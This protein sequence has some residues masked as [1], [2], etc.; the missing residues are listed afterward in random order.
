MKVY[1]KGSERICS[2]SLYHPTRGE[3][4]EWFVDRLLENIEGND[5]CEKL[6]DEDKNYFNADCLMTKRTYARLYD[7]VG[8][9]Q[10]RYDKL[11]LVHEPFRTRITSNSQQFGNFY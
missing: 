11:N 2:I 4:I 8:K 9:M 10:K 6:S 7:V 5:L 3:C 1:I